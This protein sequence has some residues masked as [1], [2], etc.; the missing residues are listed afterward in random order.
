MLD[1]YCYVYYNDNWKPYYVGKGIKKRHQVARS[2]PVPDLEHTQFFYF[3]A[4]WKACECEIE[5]IALWKR[6]IDG[7]LLENITCGG[8]G[9]LGCTG[10]LSP[11]GFLGKSH[12]P[13]VKAKLSKERSGKGNPMFGCGGSKNPFFG[14]THTEET[15]QKMKLAWIKRKEKQNVEKK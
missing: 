12:T 7:G 14:K 10:E 2:I 13:A 9:M 8:R 3:D 11:K 6:K 15:K 1:Y 5:L 4:D